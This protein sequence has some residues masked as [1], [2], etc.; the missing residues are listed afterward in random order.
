M[1]SGTFCAWCLRGLSPRIDYIEVRSPLSER[2]ERICQDCWQSIEQ[3]LI[4]E[5]LGLTLAPA[6][7]GV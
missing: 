6:T 7:K 2:T 3:P 1:S 5:A 4:I